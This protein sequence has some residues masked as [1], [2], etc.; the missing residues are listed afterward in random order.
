M[1]VKVISG[2][3]VSHGDAL[4]VGHQSHV[5]QTSNSNVT[6]MQGKD[7]AVLASFNRTQSELSSTLNKIFKVDD[8]MGI[9]MSGVTADGRILC[10]FMRNECINHRCASASAL[11]GHH[12]L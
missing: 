6:V 1:F 9:A 4:L 3:S 8:H 11:P 12:T 2:E 10:K 5:A 7:T